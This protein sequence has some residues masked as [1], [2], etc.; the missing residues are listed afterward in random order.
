M[1]KPKFHLNP[2]EETVKTI[3]EGLKRTAAI[4]PAACSI[5]RRI[6]ASARSSRSS[7]PTR[8]TT[9]RAIAGCM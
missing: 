4:A 3:R 9:V 1:E 2:N 5:F 7:W 8:T 6:S